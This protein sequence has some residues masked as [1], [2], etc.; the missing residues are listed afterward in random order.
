[1]DLSRW[2]WT[3]ACCGQR[4][5]GVPD[6]AYD[7][8][9]HAQWAADGEP[10]F[11][12]LWATADDCGMKIGGQPVHFVRCVLE[13]PVHAADRPFGYGVWTTLSAENHKRYM[14]T[15]DAT[16]QASLG[17][18]F[19]YLANRLPAYPDTLNLK[20]DV[21][22]RD[23]R[24]RP[25]VELWDEGDHPLVRDQREG[26]DAGQLEALLSRILPCDGRA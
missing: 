3:C 10:D 23:N 22:P 18:M 7:R 21:V 4:K 25:L 11:E 16:D 8:P 15:F 6:L 13:I 5:R 20:A 12:L 2:E 26:L 9:I 1:M 14:E 17:R 19:G 24:Q